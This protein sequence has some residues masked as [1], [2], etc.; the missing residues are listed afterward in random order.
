MGEYSALLAD[1]VLR[2]RARV[3]EHAARIESQL[4]SKVKSEFI[5]NMSHELRTP[6]NTVIGFAK[7][8]SEHETR[9]IKNAEVIEY[10]GLIRD[11]ATHLLAVINDILDISKMQSGKYT[12]DACEVDLGEILRAAVANFKP[13]ASELGV[14][15]ESNIQTMLPHVKGD[16]AKLRQIFGNLISNAIRFTPPGG[17]ISIEATTHSGGG[18]AV[19]VCDTGIGMTKDEIAVAL[20]P[21]GQVDAGR[22]RWREGAGLGLPIAKA[23]I[24]LHGGRLEIRSAKSLGTEVGVFLPPAAEVSVMHGRDLLLGAGADFIPEGE[25][26]GT[27]GHAT[28]SAA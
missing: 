24:Q 14:T 11:A 26:E 5:S 9:Q 1:A 8:L 17:V 16:P 7:L 28:P 4:A 25:H 19:F 10:A 6:L 18:T 22:S 23:L 12:L 21:F 13:S 2:H 3:A 27:I 15:L 20:T